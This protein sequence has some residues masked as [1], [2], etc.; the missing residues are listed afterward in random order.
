M[1][2]SNIFG[3]IATA[4]RRVQK[5]NYGYFIFLLLT[6]FGM[7]LLNMTD[8]PTLSDDMV[9]HFM[10]SENPDAEVQTIE[11]I[12]DL[13]RSQWSHYLCVNG[14]T[15]VHLLAQFFFVFMPAGVLHCLNA[16]L[17]VVLL[18]GCSELLGGKERLFTTMIMSFLLFTVFSGFRSAML[19]GLGALNYL[20]VLVVTIAFLL[21]MKEAKRSRYVWL[22]PLGLLVGWGH[23]GLSLPIS[24]GFMG[25]LILG[26]RRVKNGG[27]HDTAVNSTAFMVFYMAGTAL[28]LLSPGIWGRTGAAVSMVSRM[29][30][31][32]INCVENVHITWLL[33]I[34]LVIM[35]KQEQRLLAEHLSKWRF[36]YLALLASL[37][38]VVLCGTTLERVAFFTDFIAMLLWVDLMQQSL[39]A[40]WK[41]RLQIICGLL[42]IVSFVPAYVLRKENEKNW[43]LAEQQMKEQG[44]EMISVELPVNGENALTD[45][46]RNHYVNTSFEFGY[47]SCYMGF[48]SHDSNVRCAARMYGKEKFIFLPADVAERMAHDSIAYRKYELDKS[49]NLYVWQL[50]RG[51]KVNTVRF[52]LNDEDLSELSLPQRFM[53][54]EGNTY[55]LDDFRFEVIEVSGRSYLVFTRPTS[56][57]Y[58]RIKSIEYE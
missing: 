17:F 25:Y 54:Y 26:V 2:L 3:V 38:I 19:W 35:W 51:R 12:V 57:I 53:A 52:I 43:I 48:D 34:T 15:I 8:A 6:G 21:L 49:K 27:G 56:N 50:P 30:S 9:Y 46:F 22:A 24:V 41:R 5:E 58:R 31:G 36:V 23:E 18:H 13:F 45:Y 37:G 7:L 16:L 29:V 42:L 14:R 32:A 20:W 47:Y 10:W 40:V 1:V 39:S 44:K 33:L 28:C 4:L 55:E 11:S